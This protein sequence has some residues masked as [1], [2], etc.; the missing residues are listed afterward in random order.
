MKHSSQFFLIPAILIFN[1]I[2]LYSQHLPAL[3]TPETEEKALERVNYKAIEERIAEIRMGDLIVIT[4]PGSKVIVEQVSHEFLFGTAIPNSLA[5][6]SRSPMSE[7]D[8]DKYLKILSENFNYAVHENAVKWSNTERQKDDVDYSVADRIWELCEERGITMRGH[9][10]FWEKE[11]FIQPWLF[12]MN[13]DELRGAMVRR[14][15]SVTDHFRGRIDEFD[16]NNE[17]IHGDFFQ[18]R[19]GYGVIN[20][21]A[22]VVKATNPDVKIYLNEY[23]I[24][25]VGYNVTPFIY[26]V[27][28]LLLNGVPIDGLGLQAHRAADYSTI[29]SSMHVQRTLDAL[30]E[31]GLPIKITEALFQWD[32]EQTRVD[33]LNRLFPIYFAHPSVEAIVIW[34]FWAGSHWQPYSAWWKE[35]FT[36]TAQALAYQKLVFDKWWTSVSG[37]AD[38]NGKYQI[39]AYYGDY[40]ISSNGTRKKVTL[41]K[42]SKRLTVV[43]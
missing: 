10:I 37:Q 28:N 41:S 31:F 43:F 35:D 36:P 23:G 34:G 29:T 4:S 11:D 19:L 6:N 15:I 9:C 38:N 20:E 8:R 33:E 27:K 7:Y 40:I 22:W 42:E 14:A 24:L 1:V 5:E 3:F 17:M 25:D 21:M 26:Q 13:N 2:Q 30:A 18:R 16:L 12:D 39:R 32:E